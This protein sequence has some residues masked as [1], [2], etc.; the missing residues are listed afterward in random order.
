M[1]VLLAT[2]TMLTLCSCA[3]EGMGTKSLALSDHSGPSVPSEAECIR[4]G[5]KWGTNGLTEVAGPF[6]AVPTKDAGKSCAGSSECQGRC[7]SASNASAGSRVSG[8]CSA[9]FFAGACF[10]SVE[11][12]RAEPR[13]CN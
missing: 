10:T 12:G 8:N 2:F 7:L 6:C 3:S 4:L 5:G 1:R 11:A 13:I 9:S